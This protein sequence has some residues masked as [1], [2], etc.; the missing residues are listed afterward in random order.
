MIESHKRLAVIILVLSATGCAASR[1]DRTEAERSGTVAQRITTVS[2][3]N[4]IAGDF[5]GDGIADALVVT[6]TEVTE[7]L[8]VDGGGLN[9][10][11]TDSSITEDSLLYVG[12]FNGDGVSDFIVADRSQSREYL[13]FKG[14]LGGF[15][16]PVWSRSDLTY[17]TADYVVGDFNGDQVDDVIIVTASGS[18]EYT[19]ILNSGGFV[20][21]VWVRPDLVRGATHYTVGN[22]NGDGMDDLIISNQSGSYEYTGIFYGTFTQNVWIRT[23]LPYQRPGEGASTMYTVGDFNGDEVDDLIISTPRGSFEYVGQD[24]G[25]FAATSWQQTDLPYTNDYSPNI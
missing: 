13:G 4:R 25:G 24:W 18:Y 21:N 17:D 9:P 1:G 23:D 11:W 2:A 15:V 3:V 16:G 22:F 20:P 5:N 8:G 7:Y 12:D 10:G 19:G 14:A 6:P